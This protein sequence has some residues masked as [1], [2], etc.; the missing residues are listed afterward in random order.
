MV[1]SHSAYSWLV[2]EI[3]ISS[4]CSH[5]DKTSMHTQP[6][7][8]GSYAFIIMIAHHTPNRGLDNY[9]TALLFCQYEE[10][11]RQTLRI[12]AGAIEL[13]TTSTAACL[14]LLA[15]CG[16]RARVAAFGAQVGALKLQGLGFTGL[17][18]RFVFRI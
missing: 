14:V 18:F 16:F 7:R 1:P 12:L 11:R 15:D 17:G 13:A 8:G 9:D 10:S 4:S 2:A 5:A 6:F 3:R